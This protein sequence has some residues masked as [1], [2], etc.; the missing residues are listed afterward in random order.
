[1]SKFTERVIEGIL[2]DLEEG[3]LEEDVGPLN[4][5]AQ[6][7]YFLWKHN[8]P[9]FRDRCE[10]AVLKYKKSLIQIVNVGGIHKPAVALEILARRWPRQFGKTIKFEGTEPEDKIKKVFE[11]INE[12]T[13]DGQV[14]ASNENLLQE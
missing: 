7:T 6:R 3:A 5:I 10:N 13:K 9:E 11:L 4:G 2:K 8:M 1:M 12:A 14:S